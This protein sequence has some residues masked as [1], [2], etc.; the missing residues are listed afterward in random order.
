MNEAPIFRLI[1]RDGSLERAGPERHQHEA[2]RLREELIRGNESAHGRV[3]REHAAIDHSETLARSVLDQGRREVRRS[4]RCCAGNISQPEIQFGW[5]VAGIDACAL[6]L[7]GFEEVG[8]PWYQQT[9][10][11]TGYLKRKLY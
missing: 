7:P 8:S 9:Q 2:L 3:V 1:I 5:L 4:R 11:I 10:P 6:R